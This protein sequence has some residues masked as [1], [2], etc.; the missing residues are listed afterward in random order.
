VTVLTTCADA[1]AAARRTCEE[2]AL[3]LERACAQERA[4]HVALSGGETPRR[5][6]ELLAAEPARWRTAEVW[7]AD[8]RCVAPEHEDS[9]Y[10]LA[11]EALLDRAAIP[12][13]RVH[14][15]EG[16]LGPE[17]GARRYAD[18]L[19]S[20]LTRDEDGSPVLDVIVLGI[21]PDGHVASLFPEAD[22]LSAGPEAVCLGVHDSPKPPPERITL[23]LPVLRAARRCVMLALGS[24]KAAAVAGMLGEPTPCVPASLL[25]RGRL[26]VIV[27]DAAAPPASPP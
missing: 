25:R 16:E 10:R 11:A 19:R 13:P 21:G 5:A 24:E 27:D 23:T 17:Q 4:V 2:V 3:E 7:F 22:T 1:E 26:T 20:R 8:E 14:R 12:A 9:N 18:A 6:Y 15:M